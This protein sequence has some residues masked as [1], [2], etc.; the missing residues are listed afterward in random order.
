MKGFV[1]K[2]IL[3]LIANLGSGG[4]E[5]QII[6]ITRLL[7][8]RGYEVELVCYD[9]TGTFYAP[10]LYEDGIYV[11]WVVSKNYLSRIIK[12]RNFIRNGNYDVV[13]SFLDTPNF[14]NCIAATGGKTWKVITSERSAKET[15]FKSLRGR[16]F[17][18]FQRYSDHIVCNSDNAKN[19]YLKYHPKYSK[20][21]LVIRNTVQLPKID[22]RYEPKKYGKLYIIIAASYQPLKNPLGLIEALTLLNKQEKSKIKIDW[23]GQKSITG[24]TQVYDLAKRLVEENHLEDVINLN[25]EIT[26]IADKM[27]EADVVALFSRVE[28][29]P[30]VICEG[31]TIGKP[32]IMTRV[33]DYS[34]LVDENNGFLCDWDNPESIKNALV[35]A[36]NLSFEQLKKMGDISKQ[37]AEE[38]FSQK[39]ILD[40]WASAIEQ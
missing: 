15:F 7:K 31:M 10:L 24:D 22:S 37:K 39:I 40:Q 14:L 25:E 36:S 27:D 16:I 2:R 20:K 38:L 26:T 23:Y 3:F 13:I 34:A 33:S 12:I 17:K 28:G 4:A 9:K 18:W 32:I 5:R 29:L 19:M 35:T 6:T 1:V 8:Q 11:H 21:L 30:N